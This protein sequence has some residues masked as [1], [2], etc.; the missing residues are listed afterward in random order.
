[1][2]AELYAQYSATYSGSN[3]DDIW[4]AVFTMCDLF[5]TL[6]IHVAKHFGYIY[7]QDEEDG[8]RRYIK[9]VREEA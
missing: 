6:A 7:R 4:A 8:M 1:L 3:Y 9:I 2:P 5:H